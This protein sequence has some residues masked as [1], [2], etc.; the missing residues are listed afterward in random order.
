MAL[1][2]QL[3][4]FDEVDVFSTVRK[5][6]K[7]YPSLLEDVVSVEK[8]G[9]LWMVSFL[10]LCYLSLSLSPTFVFLLTLHLSLPLLHFS[11]HSPFQSLFIRLPLFLTF[12][13][14]SLTIYIHLS[15]SLYSFLSLSSLSILS[16]LPLSLSL[17]IDLSLSLCRT[18]RQLKLMRSMCSV[19][20]GR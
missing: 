2:D 18:S 16:S 17:S 12:S 14:F 9:L 20:C 4:A 19:Q 13:L 10:S 6:R 1:C 11:P 15:Q 7:M 5:Y 3:K 8:Y